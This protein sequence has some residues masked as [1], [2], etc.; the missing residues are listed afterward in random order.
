M[1]VLIDGTKGEALLDFAGS[2]YEVMGNCNAPRA[3]TYSAIIYAMRSMVQKDI[4]L[5]QVING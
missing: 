4:P 5:N 2:G 1:Q 3:V